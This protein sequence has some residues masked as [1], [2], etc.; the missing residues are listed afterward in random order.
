MMDKFN[1][2]VVKKL[3]VVKNIEAPVTITE[4]LEVTADNGMMPILGNFCAAVILL[5]ATVNT[6]GDM[7]TSMKLYANT[8]GAF[9]MILSFV[10]LTGI[11]QVVA[12]SFYIRYALF[13]WCFIGSCILTFGTGPFSSTGNGYFCSWALAIFSFMNLG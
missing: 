12:V 4:D 13:F 5:V 3:D 10:L 11:K 2:P 9:A 7:N 8:V 1:I 6:S